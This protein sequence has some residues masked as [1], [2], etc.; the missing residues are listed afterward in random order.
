MCECL[1]L[2]DHR[3]KKSV[4][5]VKPVRTETIYFIVITA[6]YNDHVYGIFNFLFLSYESIPFILQIALLLVQ[7]KTNWSAAFYK[8]FWHPALQ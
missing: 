5:S 7:L 1:D 4:L 6:P 3:Q 8:I 2:Y